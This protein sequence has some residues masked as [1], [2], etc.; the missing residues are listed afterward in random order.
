MTSNNPDQYPSNQA[1]GDQGY[2]AGPPPYQ[3]GG[4]QGYPAGPP[5][6]QG[7]N[8]PAYGGYNG[9]TE[10]NS[11][12]GWALGLGIASIVCCGPLTGIPAIILGIL[13]LQAAKEGR[14]TNNA[15]S[16]I[17][18]ALGAMGI[19]LT[20]VGFLTGTYTDLIGS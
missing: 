9:G 16:I 13:G 20:I 4:D 12:G 14:A 18:I 6:Y 10:K 11:L 3:T 2:P 8:G 17:G 5:P 15:L 19:I 7:H 1:G